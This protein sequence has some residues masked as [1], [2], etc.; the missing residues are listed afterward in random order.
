[1]INS[2]GFERNR[3][4]RARQEAIN[5]ND[6]TRKRFEIMARAVFAKFKACLTLPGIND[7]RASEGAINIIYKSLQE[8]RDAADISHIIQQ[9]HSVIEPAITVR[10]DSPGDGRIYDIS[11][12]DFD[13]LRREFER[14]PPTSK[15]TVHNLKDAI[16]KR[17]AQMLAQNPL[18]TNFQQRYEEIVAEY[19][20]EK[21]RVTIETT[22]EA[23]MRFMG[24]LDEEATARYTR[25]AG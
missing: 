22:F 12:I 19:N 16:E 2:S 18:R 23:L 4:D 15:P 13:L 6:E 20:G 14:H 10:S 3:R 21:D 7:Y 1:M 17:L 25:G 9:L 5:E 8:D 11:A 24:E